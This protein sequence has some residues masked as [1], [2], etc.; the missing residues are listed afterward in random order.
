MLVPGQG[1][2]PQPLGSEP[3]VLSLHQPGMAHE[4]GTAPSLPVLE[5]GPRTC[6]SCL[7]ERRGLEPRSGRVPLQAVRAVDSYAPRLM[8]TAAGLYSTAG[9]I[10]FVHSGASGSSVRHSPAT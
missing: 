2:K 1:F 6:G 10:S 9:N 4:L 8:N 3:S 5:T 7:V